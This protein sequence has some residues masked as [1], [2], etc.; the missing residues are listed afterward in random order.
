M[1][2][3]LIVL[4]PLLGFAIN[5]LFGAKMKKPLPGYIATAAVFGAFVVALLRVLEL[6][7]RDAKNTRGEKHNN[8]GA[9]IHISTSCCASYFRQS[10]VA[11]NRSEGQA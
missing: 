11:E 9:F 3:Y 7:P 2:L 4:L 10:I 8:F 6:R 1:P 5:G